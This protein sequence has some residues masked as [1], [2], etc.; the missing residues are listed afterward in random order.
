M[1]NDT[2]NPGNGN[3]TIASVLNPNGDTA[4][5]RGNAPVQQIEAAAPQAKGDTVAEQAMS[6]IHGVADLFGRH[7]EN[8]AE[9]EHRYT[10]QDA[11]DA[12]VDAFKDTAAAQALTSAEEAISVRVA[13]LQAD[14]ERQN[15]ALAANF[16]SP[17]DELRAQ[18][19]WSREKERLDS[20]RVGNLLHEIQSA[21]EKGSPEQRRVLAQELP[22][23][24]E[25]RGLTTKVV[26]VALSTAAP[27]LASARD[28]LAKAERAQAKVKHMA[29]AVRLGIETRQPVRVKVGL[30]KT[31]DPDK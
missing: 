5:Q 27:E 28:R 14:V 20:T 12:Q 15:A 18:R 16:T 4:F 2:F 7:L 30:D 9:I 23:Y 25:S 21:L 3:G 22:A 19:D 6:Q 17:E 1:P 8:V 11:I 24:V 26:D 29:D 31:D 10:D 13:E